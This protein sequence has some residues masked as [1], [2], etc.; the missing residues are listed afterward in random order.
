MPTF[1]L[2]KTYLDCQT[3]NGETIVC[4]A[5]LL[6]L[7]H[8]KFRH[9]SWLQLLPDGTTTRRQTFIRGS[10]PEETEQGDILWQCGILHAAGHWQ[11]EHPVLPIQTLHTERGLTTDW[12]CLQPRSR[13]ALRL[14]NRHYEGIGYA[15]RLHMTL[16]PWK[17]PIDT[18]HWG[19]FLG[20]EGSAVIWIIWEG[21][22]PVTLL[23]N[24]QGRLHT[25]GLHAS[26]DGAFL[27]TNA[28]RLDFDRRHILRKGAIGSTVLHSFP[29]LAKKLLPPSILHLHECKWAGRATLTT[30]SGTETGLSIH[31]I[32]RFSP[33]S[34]S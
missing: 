25:A 3:E 14:E 12:H 16:P 9:A 33:P 19:R 20:N 31:E 32:V 5:S 11:A 30:P 21:P 22:N 29:V 13:V 27:R 23:W 4:Y 2:T 7:G 26:A 15:E 10:M 1:S 6:S 8:L 18:L 34:A 17:L 28:L 24:T